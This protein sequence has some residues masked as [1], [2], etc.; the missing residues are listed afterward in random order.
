MLRVF[1]EWVVG[2]DRSAGMAPV[3]GNERQGIGAERVAD[4]M[5]VAVSPGLGTSP[6][7]PWRVF[8]PPAVYIVELVAAEAA[9][10]EH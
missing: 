9:S 4:L 7:T 2:T 1:F 8:C 10:A 5:V 3:N 6:F